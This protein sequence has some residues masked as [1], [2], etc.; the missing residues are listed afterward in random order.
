M[1]EESAHLRNTCTSIFLYLVSLTPLREIGCGV[2]LDIRVAKKNLSLEKFNSP[3]G[4][5]TFC[6]THR[7]EN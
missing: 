5:Y 4:F 6:D 2:N 1:F 3:G 7:G